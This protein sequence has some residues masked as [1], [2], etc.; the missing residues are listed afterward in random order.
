MITPMTTLILVVFRLSF[1]FCIFAALPY[2]NVAQ[3]Q[4]RRLTLRSQHELS[5]GAIEADNI[6]AFHGETFTMHYCADN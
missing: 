2:K 4:R 1:C 6:Y 3:R 5:A